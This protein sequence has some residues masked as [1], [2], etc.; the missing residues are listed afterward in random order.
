MQVGW[1]EGECQDR[2]LTNLCL[3]NKFD[4]GAVKQAQLS[5]WETHK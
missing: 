2:C 1:V 4:L 5:I 3:S